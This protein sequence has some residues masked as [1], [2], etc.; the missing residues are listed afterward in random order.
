[1][2]GEHVPEGLVLGAT[3]QLCIYLGISYQHGT[4]VQASRDG[5]NRW[6]VEMA[7]V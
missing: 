6:E 4:S 2:A 3:T 1:M 5:V 7:G